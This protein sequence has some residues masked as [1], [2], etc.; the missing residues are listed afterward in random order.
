MKDLVIQYAHSETYTYI[1]NLRLHE[2]GSE[3]EV[4]G[5]LKAACYG[6]FRV[7]RQEIKVGGD[8]DREAC[9][10]TFKNS[11]RNAIHIERRAAFHLVKI[12]GKF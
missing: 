12:Y 6:V 4:D 7:A 11:K 10:N 9:A 3:T 1:M 8:A 2:K 5:A